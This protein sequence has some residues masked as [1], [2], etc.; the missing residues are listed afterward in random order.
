M[1]D[2][3]FEQMCFVEGAVHLQGVRESKMS[4][5]RCGCLGELDDRRR[6]LE[7]YITLETPQTTRE[8]NTRASDGIPNTQLPS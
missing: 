2:N 3:Y 4:P 8:A 6:R 5:Q 7:A 1:C